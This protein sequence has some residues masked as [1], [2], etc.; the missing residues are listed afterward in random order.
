LIPLTGETFTEKTA[1]LKDDARLDVAARGFWISGQKAFFD[2]RVFNPFAKRYRNQEIEKCYVV[3][4]KE[5]KRSYNERILNVEN[6]SFTPL[7]MSSNGGLAKECENF[8][9]RLAEMLSEKRKT[10]YSIVAA[11]VKRK[12]SF[13]LIR[14]LILCIRGSRSI[15]NDEITTSIDNNIAISEQLVTID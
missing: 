12:I 4:E 9:K 13:S 15:F 10:N 3:N 5:K 11:W 6:G 1:N 2:V 7:V 14:S 8:Y